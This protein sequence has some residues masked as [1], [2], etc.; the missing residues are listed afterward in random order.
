MHVPS[1]HILLG[2]LL[3]LAV[4]LAPPLAGPAS[5][6]CGCDHPLPMAAPVMPPFGFPGST[7][8]L[9]GTGGFVPGNV[10]TAEFRSTGPLSFP[11]RVKGRARSTSSLDVPVPIGLLA[12][13]ASI[14]VTG[15]N[16]DRTYGSELFTALATPRR[17]PQGDLVYAANDYVGAVSHDGTL[18][19]PVDLSEIADAEQFALVMVDLPLRFGVDDVTFYNQHGIDLTLFTMAVSN[20]NERQWGSYYGWDVETDSGLVHTVYENK[21]LHSPQPGQQSDLL[22]YWRHEFHTYKAAHGV[23]GSHEVDGDGFHPDGTFH[24]DHDRLVLAINTRGQLTPGRKRFDLLLTAVTA[25]QPVEPD[26]MAAKSSSSQV[27]VERN[28]FLTDIVN[29]ITGGN[30]LVLGLPRD[31]D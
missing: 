29:S 23:G 13:P 5:A 11:L 27:L 25:P 20:P 21:V 14:R 19:I 3:A 26:V 16:F 9:D 18:L 10:Y 17:I 1:R 12:G 8:R 31:D 24:V 28:G 2:S 4:L 30:F 22:T 15:S 7:I 6:G